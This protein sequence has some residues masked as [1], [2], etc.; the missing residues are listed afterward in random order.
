MELE[1]ETGLEPATLACNARLRRRV[2]TIVLELGGVDDHGC[3]EPD[4][5]RYHRFACLAL[6][7]VLRIIFHEKRKDQP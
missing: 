2:E 5:S 6:S 4:Q 3:R 1:R 7:N